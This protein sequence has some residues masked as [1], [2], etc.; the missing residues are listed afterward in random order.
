VDEWEKAYFEVPKE[1]RVFV[2]LRNLAPSQLRNLL[3][4]KQAQEYGI[5]R[6]LAQVN[7]EQRAGTIKE[8]RAK[9]LRSMIREI[10]TDPAY[11]ETTGLTREIDEKVRK[12]A[13]KYR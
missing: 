1:R 10:T 2:D 11:T 9:A 12:A 8:A 3:A 13:E 6:L 4:A 5:E 7:G